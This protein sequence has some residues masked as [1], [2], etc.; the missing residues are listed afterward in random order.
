[1]IVTRVR[2]DVVSLQI[3]TIDKTTLRWL[4]VSVTVSVE[5]GSSKVGRD[6][7]VCEETAFHFELSGAL[8][9]IF[10][11]LLCVGSVLLWLFLLVL[12]LPLQITPHLPFR[13]HLLLLLFLL[14]LLLGGSLGLSLFLTF[15]VVSVTILLILLVVAFA[16]R[17]VVL[18]RVFPI[19]LQL[20]SLV[21][22][23]RQLL[24]C[25]WVEAK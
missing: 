13:R 12:R 11:L 4:H 18:L 6:C 10:K 3:V 8:L 25:F 1:M 15:V 16:E 22:L 7:G 24:Q 14:N 17:P 21:K 23:G 5:G 2:V 9:N 20:D 19:F